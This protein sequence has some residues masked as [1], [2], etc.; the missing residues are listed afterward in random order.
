MEKSSRLQLGPSLLAEAVSALQLVESAR[1]ICKLVT[2]HWGTGTGLRL[3][4]QA[5]ELQGAAACAMH[6]GRHDAGVMHAPSQ[7]PGVSRQHMR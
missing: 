1:L 5:G 4:A 3:D 7:S 2:D 6:T